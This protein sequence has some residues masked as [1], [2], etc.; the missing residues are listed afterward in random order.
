MGLCQ[1]FLGAMGFHCGLILCI[2][3]QNSYLFRDQRPVLSFTID[4][5]LWRRL[6]IYHSIS[7]LVM[8]S[9]FYELSQHMATRH[10]ASQ[11]LELHDSS[12][13]DKFWHNLNHFK[14]SF[15]QITLSISIIKTI[16]FGT[17]E[18]KC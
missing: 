12:I 8:E 14:Y 2:V 5:P 4:A 11:K 13:A 16:T 7:K 10:E 3:D 6:I 15:L 18:L 9:H 1:N 17:M